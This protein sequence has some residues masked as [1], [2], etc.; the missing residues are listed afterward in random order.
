MLL[1]YVII[2]YNEREYLAQAI[3]SC[4]QQSVEESEIIIADDG[5]NDGSIELIQEYAAKYPD[6]IRYFVN[7]RSDVIPGKV[8]ASI[9][10]SNNLKR[11]LSMA[12]GKYC[13]LLSGDDFLY[14]GSFGRDAVAFLD[15]HPDHSAYV[16]GFSMYWPDRPGYVC[17]PYVPKA[18]CWFVANLH[19]SVFVFRKSIFDEGKFLNRF[20]D[21]T[22]LY[23][24]LAI[25]GKW[26]YTQDVVMGYRQRGGSIM[27]EADKLELHVMELMLMQDV[28][29]DKK[30][31]LQTLSRF[32]EPLCYVFKHR[33]ELTKPKYEK[34]LENCAQYPHDILG[35]YLNYDQLPML[36]K[37]KVRLRMLLSV[38]MRGVFKSILLGIR[39]CK[40]IY[41]ILTGR[42]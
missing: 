6:K 23:Y 39:I 5:S 37:C 41:K 18:L 10:V 1:S 35:E 25:S 9:R 7:D 2:S 40:K 4:L 27:H 17:M 22:G 11:A 8:I 24:T 33:K 21:D 15:K 19:I 13:Q 28:C 16:G 31:Y 36:Q 12:K 30:M 34:Y 14:P 42:K 3:E 26:K 20:C 38:I 32:S 29:R